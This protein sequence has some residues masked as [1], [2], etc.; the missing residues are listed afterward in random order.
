MHNSFGP[1]PICSILRFCHKRGKIKRW[2]AVRHVIVSGISMRVFFICI[3]SQ[4]KPFSD[5][6]TLH[7]FSMFVWQKC[8]DP[9][10]PQKCPGPL[11]DHP[12]PILDNFRPILTK[13]RLKT[14]ITKSYPKSYNKSYIPLLG[15]FICW[16]LLGPFICWALLGPCIC[17]ALLG[18][19]IC[20]ALLGP[21][22]FSHFSWIMK[23]WDMFYLEGRFFILF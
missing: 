4:Q 10:V 17:W 23:F 5:V 18:P 13:N 11:W 14:E 6:W 21:F 15:P 20:W 8:F 1:G 2:G 3:F 12:R 9:K 7:V 22:I 16:A 19:F